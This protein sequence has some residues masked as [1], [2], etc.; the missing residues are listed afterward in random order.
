MREA[1]ECKLRE[2]LHSRNECMDLP[3]YTSLPNNYE[4]SKKGGR[5]VWKTLSPDGEKTFK[6]DKQLIKRLVPFEAQ[7]VK[8]VTHKVLH[9]QE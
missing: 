4:S 5:L 9:P 1:L 2:Y 7:Q 6:F 3:M 8:Q